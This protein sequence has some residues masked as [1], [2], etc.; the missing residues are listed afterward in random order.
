MIE[1]R[2][3]VVA[4]RDGFAWVRSR[5]N[6]TCRACAT[7]SGCGIAWISRAFSAKRAAL[8]C[9]N[10]AHARVGDEVTIGIDEGVLLKGSTLVYLAPILCMLVAALMAEALLPILGTSRAEGIIALS[11][12]IGMAGGIVCARYLSN[13]VLGGSQQRPA[14]VRRH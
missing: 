6:D 13:R 11:G 10:R 14:V 7:S 2:A 4:T 9:A 3:I 8:Q 12:V 1:E 5:G